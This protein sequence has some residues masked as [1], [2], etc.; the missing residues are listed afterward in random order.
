[1][2]NPAFDVSGSVLSRRAMKKT[3]LWGTRGL[4]WAKGPVPGFGPV[5]SLEFGQK[6]WAADTMLEHDRFL[7]GPFR[8][9]LCQD[10]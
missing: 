9:L 7:K 5:C 6:N 2:V 1:M 8:T 3:V 4:N 10:C